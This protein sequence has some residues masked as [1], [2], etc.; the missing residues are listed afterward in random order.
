VS[1]STVPDASWGDRSQ[2]VNQVER[3]VERV[4][5]RGVQRRSMAVVPLANRKAT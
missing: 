3:V 4:V 1:E 2:K 5:T